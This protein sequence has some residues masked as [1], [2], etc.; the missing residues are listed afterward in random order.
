MM[1]YNIYSIF[2]KPY[3][4]IIKGLVLV[5]LALASIVSY[6]AIPIA[7]AIFVYALLPSGIF[8]LYL[9]FSIKEIKAKNR[10]LFWF[11]LFEILMFC[12]LYIVEF[13]ERHSFELGA[14]FWWILIQC[15]LQLN[16][17]LIFKKEQRIFRILIT[18]FIVPLIF[19]IFTPI[20]EMSNI[21]YLPIEYQL[22]SVLI[23]FG[24]CNIINSI[25]LLKIKK[26]NT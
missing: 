23:F 26:S 1:I 21:L 4:L 10:R 14:M 7:N 11:G 20:L 17:A 15:I 19:L 13:V 9:A 22:I 25:V 5:F 6:S 24:I 2:K 18:L 12:F 16:Y 8:T 3:A